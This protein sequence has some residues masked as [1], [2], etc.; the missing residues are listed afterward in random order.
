[1]PNANSR[2][3]Q[4]VTDAGDPEVARMTIYGDITSGDWL[5]L[6]MGESGEGTTT[7][8]LDVAQAIADLPEACR[9][10]EVHINSYGGEV[11]EGVAIYN[12]LRASG[13]EVVTV[14]DGFACSIA[15]VIFMAGSRR[16]MRPASVLMLHDPW[17]RVQGNA[18]Q[19]RKAADDLDT[20]AELSKT[21]YL[22][23]T[24]MDA[25]ELDEVM[26]AET[27]V[28]PEQ[29]MEWGLATEVTDP[30]DGE[31]PEQSV[32]EAVMA[33]LTAAPEPMPVQSVAIAREYLQSLV[34]DVVSQVIA[35]VM[36]GQVEGQS[37]IAPQQETNY[38]RLARLLSQKSE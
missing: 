17:N 14:C 6:L 29:A 19:L 26:S 30:V 12:A 1:M 20:I 35:E 32:G 16:V 4:L 21:A 8:A 25:D 28:R 7:K 31:H 23:G 34:H 2:V 11:A 24:K 13:R 22:T 33:A 5:S 10:V 38:Q 18:T 36:P 3:M 9:T 27:W 37:P 15:S